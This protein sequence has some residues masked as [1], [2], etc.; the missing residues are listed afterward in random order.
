MAITL[1][2]SVASPRAAIDAV[3]VD[4]AGASEN[5]VADYD[6]DDYPTQAEIRC[7]IAFLEGGVEYG[8][9]YVFAVGE[10]GTHQFNNYIFPHDGTWTMRLARNDNDAVLKDQSITV[11][12]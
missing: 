5:D 10:D 12:T 4:V 9:S 11:T 2:P 7:Y 3:R 6:T 8:R 1:T